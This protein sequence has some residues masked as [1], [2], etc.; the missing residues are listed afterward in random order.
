MIVFESG[1]RSKIQF[2]MFRLLILTIGIF[3]SLFSV[4][5][6]E[7]LSPHSIEDEISTGNSANECKNSDPCKIIETRL[8]NISGSEL[9][10]VFGNKKYC[11]YRGIRYGKAPIGDLRFKV[12]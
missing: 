1:T 7:L 5:N 11:G 10:T 2:E 4:I 6:C 12:K 8:G 3:L 9:T